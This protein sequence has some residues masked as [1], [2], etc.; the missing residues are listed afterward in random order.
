MLLDTYAFQQACEKL[1][2]LVIGDLMVDR[3]LW[4]AVERISP[5][6]PVPVVDISKEENRLGGAANVALNIQAIGARPV[7]CGVVGVDKDGEILRE[8]AENSHFQTDLIFPSTERRTTVKVRVIGNQQQVLRVDKEDRYPLSQVEKE[9]ILPK[10]LERI[11]DFDAIIFEDYD[12]SMLGAEL[13][14]KVIAEA[15]RYSVPT[16]VDP[17]FKQFWDYAGVTVFKPNMKELNEGLGLRLHKQDMEGITSAIKQLREQ[18]PH[19]QTL[20][21]LSENGMLLVDENFK[22]HHFPAHYRNI[23]D[24]SGAGDTVIGVTATAMAAGMPLP[25]AVAMA[26]L[27]GGL[28]CEEVGVVPVNRV[29][30]MEEVM[31]LRK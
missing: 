30:L 28:V 10:L 7:L 22:A 8:L 31:K 24:V 4:G 17:K 2:I 20:I 12:K 21:T 13:I 19:H 26:N 27:A 11:S 25:Q 14:Q 23:T 3:Y 29:K 6:A 15:Q 18:M 1:N 5:E 9:F 16:L